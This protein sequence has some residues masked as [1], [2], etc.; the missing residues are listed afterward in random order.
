[1]ANLDDIDRRLLAELQAEG[2]VT[3]VELAQRVG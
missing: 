1:M 3:N 2:R